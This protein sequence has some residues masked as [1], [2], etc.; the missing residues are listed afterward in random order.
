MPAAKLFKAMKI[1]K[2]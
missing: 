1:T 2:K